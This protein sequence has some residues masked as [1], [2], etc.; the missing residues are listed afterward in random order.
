MSCKYLASGT[1]LEAPF[2]GILSVGLSGAYVRV[3]CVKPKGE[4][5]FGRLH[6]GQQ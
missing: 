4:L 5:A 1:S 6:T 3:V 2:H